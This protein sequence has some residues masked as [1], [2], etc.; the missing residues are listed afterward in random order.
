MGG[1]FDIFGSANQYITL[2]RD[3][4]TIAGAVT[5]LAAGGRILVK[6]FVVDPFGPR[7]PL[8]PRYQKFFQSLVYKVQK[9]NSILEPPVVV[10]GGD[11]CNFTSKEV[12]TIRYYVHFQDGGNFRVF[13]DATG[14]DRYAVYVGLKAR[15]AALQK[16]FREELIWNEGATRVII[17]CPYGSKI[18]IDARRLKRM[19]KWAIRRVITFQR[20]FDPKV[21]EVRALA[22][23]QQPVAAAQVG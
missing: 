15:S 8:P 2:I 12:S 6:R 11:N 20:V 16:H 17:N 5:L 19:R 18:G 22:T 9:R 4:A 10:C 3:L 13:L 1:L 7:D 21:R 23:V 14:Q